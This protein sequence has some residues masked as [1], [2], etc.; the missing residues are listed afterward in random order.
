MIYTAITI[1]IGYHISVKSSA[2]CSAAH[3]EPNPGSSWGPHRTGFSAIFGLPRTSHSVQR[4]Q[5]P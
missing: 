5:G 3:F 1:N 4:L 2:L